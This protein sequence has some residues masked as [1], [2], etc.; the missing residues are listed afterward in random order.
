TRTCTSFRTE[1]F[2]P[3][4]ALQLRHAPTA[5]T[6][7]TTTLSPPSCQCPMIQTACAGSG[8]RLEAP[9]GFEPPN[10]GFA[11][12]CLTTWLRRHSPV[13]PSDCR[14][15]VRHLPETAGRRPA[16]ALTVR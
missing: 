15:L 11:V 5:S 16:H 12:R 6:R 3:S 7:T 8:F 10:N 9:G 14:T 2:R 13:E 1:G 4:A